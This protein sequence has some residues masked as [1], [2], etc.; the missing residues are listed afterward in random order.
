M[1][2]TGSSPTSISLLGAATFYPGS[3]LGFDTS[4]GNF[5]YSSNLG[6]SLGLSKL[7][8]NTLTLTGANNTYA[9]GTTVNAGVLQIGDGLTSPGSLPGNVVISSTTPSALA[10]DLPAGESHRQRQHQRQRRRQRRSDRQRRRVHPERQPQLRR[11]ANRGRRH[12]DP[13]RQQQLRQHPLRWRRQSL[14]RQPNHNQRRRAQLRSSRQSSAGPELLAIPGHAQRQPSDLQRH[15]AL[16][17]RGRA[18]S[19]DPPAPT[20]ATARSTWRTLAAAW[21]FS[22]AS[23]A[24]PCTKPG[25]AR[26]NSAAPATTAD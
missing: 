10:F 17:R 16:H 11:L 8:G 18:V 1:G 15:A 5:T 2:A 14:D 13:H 6:G 25:P 24:A 19:T 3:L 23:P 22:G 20:S 21:P 4:D 12:G 7:G 9:G 26:W